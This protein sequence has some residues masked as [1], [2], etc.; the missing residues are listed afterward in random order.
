MRSVLRATSVIATLVACGKPATMPKPPGDLDVVD[1]GVGDAPAVGDA[2]PGVD[3]AVTNYGERPAAT[4]PKVTLKVGVAQSLGGLKI[5]LTA[6][7]HKHAVGGDTLGIFEFEIQRGTKT[8][9]LELRSMEVGFESELDVHGSLL[10]FRHVAGGEFV[11]TLA[12]QRTP[13]PQTEE[14]C[15]A[16]IDAGATAAGHPTTSSRSYTDANGVLVMLTRSWRGYCG[17]YTRRVW[18]AAPRSK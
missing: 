3:A 6:Q 9:Q 1:A 13:A 15:A 8:R 17:R 18:F 12:A 10:V 5:K 11:A 14:E 7:N 16:L 4:G 2:V